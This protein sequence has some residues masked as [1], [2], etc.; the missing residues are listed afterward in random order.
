VIRL[1]VICIGVL[2]SGALQAHDPITTKITFSTEIS[3]LFHKRC[4]SCHQEGGPAPMSLATYAEARPWAKAIKEEVLERRMP[5]WGA[6]KGFG[7][8]AGDQ[9]LT[10]EEVS[11]IADWVEGGAPEGEP[12]FLP[13][14]PLPDPPVSQPKRVPGKRLSVKK[15]LSLTTPFQLT[16]IAPVT[17]TEIANV[18]LIAELPDGSVEPL[19]WLRNYK[20]AFKHT[21][22]LRKPLALK[23]GA[24]IVVEPAGAAAFT[25]IGRP[26]SGGP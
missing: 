7:S 20:P 11:L 17:T 10:Q 12:K 26:G 6:V 8:F 4:L 3:R 15:S 24:R 23:P 21:F 9:A 1:A 14:V 5:P 22:S 16:A 18:R 2:T 13:T 25:L 19:L